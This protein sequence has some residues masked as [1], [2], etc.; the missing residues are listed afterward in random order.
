MTAAGA[1][2]LAATALLLA[3]A[4]PAAAAAPRPDA[5]DR[6]LA[7]LLAR[8]VAVFRAVATREGTGTS[9][10]SLQR[11]AVVKKSPSQAFAAAIAVTP[12]LLAEIVDRFRPQLVSLRN[13]ID[14][15]H[16]DSALFA[17]WIGAERQSFALLM[18]FDNHGKKV[19]L[20]AAATVMLD[21]TSTPADLRRV[22]GLDPAVIAELFES[23][24]SATLTRLAPRMQTFLVAAGVSKKSAAALTS[25][26]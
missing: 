21:K 9:D 16:P 11:C 13:T 15:I 7:A 6:A 12:A 26:S 14:A 20:C 17:R 22:F 18:K 5:H 8:Q 10:T 3:T 19:D 2:L 24:A 4:L 1:R 25:P 23:K